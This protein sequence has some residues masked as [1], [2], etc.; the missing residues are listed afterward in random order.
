MST[1]ALVD[2]IE[3][4]INNFEV[5][6]TYYYS[7]SSSKKKKLSSQEG[8]YF[9]L[10]IGTCS[11]KGGNL[12][13]DCSPC[14]Y[15]PSESFKAK[16]TGIEVTIS[17]MNVLYETSKLTNRKIFDN[18]LNF[19]S[20]TLED[21]TDY[22]L[23]EMRVTPKSGLLF[24]EPI[25]INPKYRET[26]LELY[27][28][29][30]DFEEVAPV[31]EPI[32]SMYNIWKAKNAA[33]T[34]VI[35]ISHLGTT[36]L[37]F[38]NNNLDTSNIIRSQIGYDQCA[39]LFLKLFDLKYSGFNKIIKPK[40]V[41][42]IFDKYG[43]VSLDYR[44]QLKYLESVEYPW[45]GMSSEIKG[46]L[47]PNVILKNIIS[48]EEAK[49]Q[50]DLFA[51]DQARRREHFQRMS[52]EFQKKREEKLRIMKNELEKINL[53]LEENNWGALKELG[54]NDDK[55]VQQKKL[56]LCKKLGMET[57]IEK[58]EETFSLL[59]IPDEDLS[60]KDL[61]RK[62]VQKMRKGMLL[63]LKEKK[64]DRENSKMLLE[65]AQRENPAEYL[66]SLEDRRK[67]VIRKI[68]QIKHYSD[69]K[70]MEA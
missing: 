17:G 31:V 66:K 23:S 25:G 47:I 19:D 6:E 15:C 39:G 9:Y 33:N 26:C 14:L 67:E 57:K 7:P 13:T 5:P 32:C 44:S 3:L 4:N 70:R 24:T 30:Y 36:I 42:E 56:Y 55:D 53:L 59:D 46:D 1:S 58:E 45:S 12:S 48:P 51:Q 54:L 43:K 27:F 52:L 22:C 11:T 8:N 20:K 16:R 49:R 34:V 10:D 62:R 29:C 41:K 21:F 61:K 37:P 69:G 38:L 35:S 60:G 2:G 28:E 63:K 68:K 18:N 64:R 65:N 40:T 50:A